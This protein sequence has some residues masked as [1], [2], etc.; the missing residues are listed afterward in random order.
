M[1]QDLAFNNYRL[2]FRCD[3][4][5]DS[6]GGIVVYVKENIPCKRRH[7]LELSTIECIWLE[8]N[9]KNKKLLVGT[10]YRPPNYTLLIL[11]DIEN[12]IGLPIDTG[13]QDVVILGDLT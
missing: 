7:D 9:I 6:H 10:F 4:V 5:G 3:R 12:S 1:T 13:I 2:P 8:L 11:A